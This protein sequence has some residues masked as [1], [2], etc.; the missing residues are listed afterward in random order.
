MKKLSLF[1]TL[2]FAI[3]NLNFQSATVPKNKV[4]S[5]K[6]PTV[7][8]KAKDLIRIHSDAILT[9]AAG[10]PKIKKL[11]DDELKK[12]CTAPL[13]GDYVTVKKGTKT[14]YQGNTRVYELNRRGLGDFVI[15]CDEFDP[16]EPADYGFYDM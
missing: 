3:L 8:I 5:K 7:N 4:R 12:A 16:G 15:P 10:Y 13:N 11:T 2:F 14:L 1:L 6:N 9:S